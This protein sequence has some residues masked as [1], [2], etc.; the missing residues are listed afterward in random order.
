MQANNNPEQAESGHHSQ[1]D[2]PK[3]TMSG[4]IKLFSATLFETEASEKNKDKQLAVR[5]LPR[6]SR[7]TLLELRRQ[8]IR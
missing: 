2:K 3:K 7:Q 5:R 8:L 6:M 1:N 4:T